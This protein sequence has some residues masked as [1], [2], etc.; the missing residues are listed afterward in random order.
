M[1]SATSEF[2]FTP[3]YSMGM[4]LSED[5]QSRP[6]DVTF[7]EG[8]LNVTM[9][10]DNY[11]FEAKLVDQE[12][13]RHHLTYS[14][15]A[16]WEGEPLGYNPIEEDIN[17]VANTALGSYMSDEA[18]TMYVT[19]QFTDM[20]VDSQGYVAPPGTILSVEVYMPFDENGY[21]A[22]GKYEISTTPGADFTL[23]YGE[24]FDFL[25]ML[26]PMGTYASYIDEANTEYLGFATSGTMD[27]SGSNGYYD[28][29][30]NFTTEQGYNIT[31]S[32]SG[33]LTI[34]G[35]PGE[36][37]EDGFSTLEGDYTLDLSNA[38]G[39]GSYYGDYYY[40]GGGNWYFVLEP[41]DGLTGDGL[42][43][44]LT[45]V[46]LDFNAGL[47]TDTYV[48]AS[49]D[50]PEPGEYLV[51]YA[52]SEGQLG[53]TLFIGG[54]DSMGYVSEFAP[55]TEG[56]FNVTNHGDGTYTLS[57]SFLDDKGNTWDGEWTGEIIFDNYDTSSAGAPSRMSAGFRNN[58]ITQSEKIEILKQNRLQPIT[59][60]S[61]KATGRKVV[62]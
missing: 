18:G 17:V 56:D 36:E 25:G 59:L 13:K 16:V 44:D 51:S 61:A 5:A 33:P 2:T 34:A 31:G 58:P 38:V 4:T 12:G 47:P 60:T 10:G 50:Y 37:E 26:F 62:K 48:A 19:L 6:M 15:P 14:G 3:D 11:F 52:T 54:F 40:T 57:F 27:V 29:E 23:Y 30:F 9:D 20:P 22:E 45:G 39:Y 8:T 53:G 32:Y 55:A 43:V 42:Q 28:I 41:S 35:M 7:T 21:I 1:F 49:T 24:L 46:G